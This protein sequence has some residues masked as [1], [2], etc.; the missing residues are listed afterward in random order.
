[1]NP[2]CTCMMFTRHR[3]VDKHPIVRF[4]SRTA[5]KEIN[6]RETRHKKVQSTY[7]VLQSPVEILLF[8]LSFDWLLCSYCDC[9][10]QLSRSTSERTQRICET[11]NTKLQS[12]YIVLQSPVEIMMFVL[13]FDW[14]LCSYCDC[15]HQLS[16]STSERI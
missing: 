13:S 11:L 3:M 16:R 5:D 7:M 8:V 10:H 14:L 15:F 9:F 2:F 6:I 4:H 1:M 12:I